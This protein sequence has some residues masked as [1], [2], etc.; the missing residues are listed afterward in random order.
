MHN[1]R[2]RLSIAITLALALFGCGEA[3]QVMQAEFSTMEECLAFVRSSTGLAL[4]PMTDRPDK[5][6]G[7]LGS[8]KRNFACTQETSGTKGTYV[9]GWYDVDKD[10]QKPIASAAASAVK[11]EGTLLAVPSDPKAQYFVFE[12]GGTL[13]RPTI[14]T[15]RVGPS[16][17]SFSRREFDCSARTVRYL[18]TGDSISEMNAGSPAPAMAPVVAGAIADYVGRAACKVS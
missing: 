2:M 8:T 6:T 5:V 13:T 12:R 15:K 11:S 7:F 4:D 1:S 17:T 18:G 16:G 3:S 14:V 9:E 10:A